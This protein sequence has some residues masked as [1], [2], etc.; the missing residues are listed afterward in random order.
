MSEWH[1]AVEGTRYGPVSMEELL[2]WVQKG[3]LGADDLVWK[4]G[5][6]EWQPAR[7]V[8]ELAGAANW[9]ATAV[10]RVA[11]TPVRRQRA[12]AQ[13][14]NG[15]AVAGMVLGIVSLVLLCVWYVSILC[16]VRPA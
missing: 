3:R 1:C 12:R 9:P 2:D 15:M 11:A 8:A 16:A 10:Q 5:M 4:Q 13:K 7:T 14:G 6:A